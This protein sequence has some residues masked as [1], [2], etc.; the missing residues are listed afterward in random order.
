MHW[1]AMLEQLR[2]TGV[3]FYLLPGCYAAADLCWIRRV[4]GRFVLPGERQGQV[5]CQCTDHRPRPSAPAPTAR[6]MT[7]RSRT[8]RGVGANDSNN[9][10]GCRR[11]LPGPRACAGRLPDVQAGAADAQPVRLGIASTS[12]RTR[13]TAAAAATSAPAATCCR[14]ALATP[15]STR[16]CATR[17]TRSPA[18][19]SPTAWPRGRRQATRSSSTHVAQAPTARSRPRRRSSCSSSSPARAS[20]SRSPRQGAIRARGR[21][22]R[23][24]SRHARPRSAGGRRLR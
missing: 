18:A 8:V 21:H 16:P 12:C 2:P 4:R 7:A 3:R 5:D 11:K 19:A 15:P 22:A 9:C 13:A 14:A 17:W 24:L 10:S 1:P 6:P 20:R 23:W